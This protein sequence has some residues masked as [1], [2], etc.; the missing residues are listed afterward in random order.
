MK[1]SS[2]NS[3]Q[4]SGLWSRNRVGF[5]L[6]TVV[7]M[8]LAVLVPTQGAKA[9]A[10][11]ASSVSS[12]SPA[13]GLSSGSTLVTLTG[14]NLTGTSTVQFGSSFGT[15]V[16]NV[17]AT[18]VTVRTPAGFGTVDV[19]ITT[20]AGSVTVK[21]AFTYKS[22]TVSTVNSVNPSSGPAAGYNTVTITGTNLRGTSAVSFGTTPAVSFTI[23]SDNQITAVV[24]AG[25]ANSNVLVNATNVSG[26]QTTVATY[27]Y[28]STVC[29]PK[30]YRTTTFKYRSATLT[31][32][33]KTAIRAAAN[34]LIALGCD[35]VNLVKY[36]GSTKGASASYKAY[37]ALSNKRADAVYNVFVKQLNYK[38][39]NIKVNTIKRTT[40][41]SQS[42]KAVYDSYSSYRKVL[43]TVTRTDA[44]AGIY[45]SAGSVSG[46]QPVT[47]TGTG[48]GAVAAT[49]AIKFGNVA[50]PS[51]V[52]NA[53]GDTIIATVPAGT[54]GTAPVSIQYG[55]SGTTSAKLVYG[56]YTYVNAPTAT[57]ITP[58][59]GPTAGGNTVTIVGTGFAGVS[60][61]NAVQF[62][63]VN[64]QSYTVTPTSITAVAPANTAGSKTVTITGATGNTASISYDYVAAPT[65]ATITPN[66]GTINGGTSVT[67]TGSGLT[68]ASASSILFGSANPTNVTVNTA[69]TQIT[70]TT[71]ARSTGAVNLTIASAGGTV[72]LTNGFGYGAALTAVSPT[73]G[74][75]GAGQPV[76][77][78]GIDFPIQSSIYAVTFG[79]PTGGSFTGLTPA[80]P[81]MATSVNRVSETSITALAPAHAAGTTSIRLYTTSSS[82]VELAAAYTFVAPTITS[83]TPSTRALLGNTTITIVGTGFGTVASGITA[84]VGGASCTTPTLTVD[85]TTLT[86]VSAASTAG[87]KDVA[88]TIRG[89]SAT[90][91]GALTYV[92]APTVASL[93]VTEGTTGTIVVIT[94]TGFIAGTTV[95]FGGTSAAAI[96]T[97]STTL[98]VT[99]PAH[100]EGQVDVV[101][102][103]AGGT[104]TSTNA[105]NYVNG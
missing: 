74:P 11:T 60:G 90:A 102:S 88:V 84:T 89:N 100:A 91:A 64:A 18:S 24:P 71:P 75:T 5:A 55:V 34:E 83:V 52:I 48:F 93:N 63:G 73:M 104:V 4:V 78:T 22:N 50:S 47:I 12:V 57:L 6:L 3:N 85:H 15:A 43:L 21:N 17:S 29:A 98:T 23:N 87:A 16:T 45:P 105:F 51:Y 69:G 8:L 9:A 92:P 44:I 2:L 30:T 94:G 1:T 101:V 59:S 65:I 28:S 72:V 40:Q 7:A 36:K 103:N 19:K 25:L 38:G 95:T 81:E 14:T 33:Q 77:L 68:G 79:A 58:A 62:G 76:T 31:T 82:Y 35:Q 61:A 39:K 99:V 37:I 70:L 10:V 56:S 66:V 96:L 49:G 26:L 97:N 67:I 86:C 20:T 32:A 46:G 42:K 80:A 41:I 27:K 53:A 13:S 54:L